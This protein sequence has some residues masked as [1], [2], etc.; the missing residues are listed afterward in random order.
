ADQHVLVT[1]MVP[2]KV[3]L[4]L[5][6]A[7]VC[8][9]RPSDPYHAP[10]V[11]HK[12]VHKDKAIP[13]S[14]AYGVADAYAGVDF[15][16]EEKSDGKAVKGSYTVQLPDGRKQTVTYNADHYSGNN[17]QVEYYGEAQYPHEYGPAITFKPHG[18][19]H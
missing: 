14:F 12:P 10:P 1:A 13:Y 18:G 16:H 11:H 8:L 7:S 3:C 6:L 9:A 17:A 15:G 19:Y 4:L 2:L 5:A